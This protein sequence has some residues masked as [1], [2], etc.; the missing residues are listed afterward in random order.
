MAGVEE[1][2]GEGGMP[3]SDWGEGQVKETVTDGS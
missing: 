2:P 3:G 1:G